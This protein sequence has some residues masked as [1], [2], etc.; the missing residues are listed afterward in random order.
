MIKL[1]FNLRPFLAGEG[2]KLISAYKRLMQV[3]QGVSLDPAPNNA[4][5]TVRRKGKDHWMVD[6]GKLKRSGFKSQSWPM[7][8]R[9]FASPE[10]HSIRTSKR[11]GKTWR[12]THEQLFLY[13][14]QGHPE[15]RYSGV[16][17]KF[18]AG[19]NFPDRFSR[20]VYRQMRPQLER[21]FMRRIK[22]TL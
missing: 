11:S 16:F 14:N 6:T 4:P 19:S 21:E 12:V 10:I 1:Q 18:P 17:N 22:R 3:K 15:K 9:V 2:V 5:S 7:R 20:E 13:H 8:L